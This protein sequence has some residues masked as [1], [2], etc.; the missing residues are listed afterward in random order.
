MGSKI[1]ADLNFTIPF[2]FT[3]FVDPKLLE[4][5]REFIINDIRA[6]FELP[7]N[8]EKNSRG[9]QPPQSCPSGVT[10]HLPE[11]HWGIKDDSLNYVSID[12][13]LIVI[14]TNAEIH[15]ELT[16]G[17]VGGQDI[18]S[19]IDNISDWFKS[20]INWIWVLTGQSLNPVN[21]DPKVIHRKSQDFIITLSADKK[22]TIPKIQSPPFKI[23]MIN[24]GQLSEH[25]VI[26]EVLDLAIDNAGNSPP[27]TFEL[28]SS[29][30][31]A[32]RR[33]DRRR[34]LSDAGTA[35]ELSLSDVLGLPENHKLTLGRLVEKAI[36]E[37]VNIPPDTE[38]AF[39]KLRND[40]VHRGEISKGKSIE[41][42]LEIAEH[43][44]G[45]SVEKLIPFSSL[46]PVFRPYRQDIRI[47]QPT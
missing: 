18:H 10:R 19:L 37:G 2:D 39:V 29:A 28:L 15:F 42:A 9:L 35:S 27:L 20:F 14:P 38:D 47:I 43:I 17:Q 5:K 25:I 3:L 13:C 22:S 41:K 30:R 21:P 11:E 33:G 24:D 8:K 40:A 44:V 7:G 32:A 4:Y 34:A 16:S 45:L 12:A 31:M 26:N 36:K 1:K 23:I 6:R 46:T